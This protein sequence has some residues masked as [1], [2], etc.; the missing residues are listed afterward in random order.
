MEIKPVHDGFKQLLLLLIV[1]CLLTPVYLV[2]A[3]IS[4]IF[5]ARQGLGS[6]DLGDIVWDGKKIWVSGGGILTTKL[7]GNGHSSTDWMSYSGMDGFGQGAIAALCASGD[8]LIV[9]WTYTGQHGEET[10]TYGDGLSISV[11]SGHTWRHVPLSDI[12]P[13]RTKNAGYYTTTYDISFL[14]GTI[15]CSTTSGFLLKSED[16]GYTWVN[17]IPNDETLNLQNPNHHAQCLDIY[18]D[19]IWVG[20]FN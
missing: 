10:A 15:W 8:T 17:I 3:D 14:G 13:E 18:S 4:R 5:S 20:T 16:F 9:S 19:T 6:N 1:L 11:D 12:F 2:E 7:W